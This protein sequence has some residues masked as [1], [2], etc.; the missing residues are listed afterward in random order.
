M[1]FITPR[2]KLRTKDRNDRVGFTL[3]EMI[4]VVAILILIAALSIPAVS[5]S[6][7]SQKLNKSVDLVRT[8]MNRAR[9]KALKTGE[10][11]GFFYEPQGTTYRIAEFNAQAQDIIENGSG[12]RNDDDEIRSS[13]Y[14]YDEDR[15]PRDV[16]FVG[17]SIQD[18]ARAKMVISETNLDTGQLFPILF[19]PDG[20][21]QN[22]TLVLEN[23]DGDLMSVILRGLTGTT[24]VRKLEDE[25]EIPR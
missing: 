2:A 19:Y 18:D 10:V 14:D 12:N 16:K 25:N 24:R 17:H 20:T 22:A 3:I 7:S 5:R 13:N 1:R 21:S 9:I 8:Q 23:R 6:F 4:M 15:L 11:Y